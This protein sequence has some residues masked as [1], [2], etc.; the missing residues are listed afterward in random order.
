VQKVQQWQRDP[1]LASVREAAALA[2]LPAEEREA[3]QK[4]WADVDA[5]MAKARAK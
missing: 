4:L 1:D 2:K 3:W 5:V